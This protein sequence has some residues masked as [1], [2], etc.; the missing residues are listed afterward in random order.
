MIIMDVFWSHVIVYETINHL[1][2]TS[3]DS[4]FWWE[5]CI[6]SLVVHCAVGK[7]RLTLS[8]GFWFGTG[9]DTRTF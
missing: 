2:A 7:G 4:H 9:L 3:F 1:P 8:A 6:H 5:H